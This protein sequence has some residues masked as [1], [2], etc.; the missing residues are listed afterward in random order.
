MVSRVVDGRTWLVDVGWKVLV[1]WLRRFL[2]A[3][4]FHFL[5][6]C[7]D[8]IVVYFGVVE[9][10]IMDGSIVVAFELKL[11]SEA[12]DGSEEFVCVGGRIF[13]TGHGV[14]IGVIDGSG[15]VVVFWD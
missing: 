2:M 7:V 4:T 5:F 1:G 12:L 15:D 14:A 13:V 8:F 11:G 10:V 6:D 3:K 9:E